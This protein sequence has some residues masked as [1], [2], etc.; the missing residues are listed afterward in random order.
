MAETPGQ[1]VAAALPKRDL[2]ARLLAEQ[3][4]RGLTLLRRLGARD[5]ESVAHDLQ[6]WQGCNERLLRLVSAS[7]EVWQNHLRTVSARITASA[8]LSSPAEVDDVRNDIRELASVL[9]TLGFSETEPEASGPAVGSGELLA[10]D[11]VLVVYGRNEGAKEKVARFLMKL[12]LEPVLLDEEAARGRT[13]I[14]KLE[15]QWPVAFV[16]VLLTGDDVG[17][18][19]PEPRTLRPRARQN[20]IFELGYSIAKLHRE[21]VCV[22]YEERVELPSDFHGVEYKPL[23]AAGAWKAKLAKELH[24]AGLRFDPLRILDA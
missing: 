4:R 11:R 16:V 14:E 24:E 19:G 23:D 22:L 12:Q 5:D 8:H 9:H 18:L 6:A 2:H 15:T 20:V 13:L 17:G 7:Y 1:L 3:I 10:V 21:R